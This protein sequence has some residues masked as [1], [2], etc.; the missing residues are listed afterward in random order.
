MLW[1]SWS[2]VYGWSVVVWL[3]GSSRPFATRP[4]GMANAFRGSCRILRLWCGC[5]LVAMILLRWT[6]RSLVALW[7]VLDWRW[8]HRLL[9]WLMLVMLLLHVGRL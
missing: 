8:L 2:L 1:H 6:W 3:N 4:V 5:G 7:V 9:L